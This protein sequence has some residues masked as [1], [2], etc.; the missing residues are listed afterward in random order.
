VFQ[1][2]GWY[3]G[4]SRSTHMG[5]YIYTI[6]GSLSHGIVLTIQAIRYN[7]PIRSNH[8]NWQREKE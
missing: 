6:E 1:K 3:L 5:S 4:K 7:Y 8:D 2:L